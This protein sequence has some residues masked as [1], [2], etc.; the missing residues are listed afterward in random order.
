MNAPSG[1]ITA[2]NVLPVVAQPSSRFGVDPATL[3]DPS[4][5]IEHILKRYHEVHRG[6]LPELIR[7]A[8]KV[9]TV[10]AGHPDVPVGLVDL[11]EYMEQ[12]LLLHM[13]KEERM[14]FPLL[15]V[16]GNPFV[17]QPISMMRAEHIEHVV[18]LNKLATLTHDATPPEGA[19]S[20][21]RALYSGI[22]QLRNELIQHIDLENNVL[23]AQFDA[24]WEKLPGTPFEDDRK[25][26]Q[27]FNHR[28]TEQP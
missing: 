8:Q 10:H 6:Q 17:N 25:R 28:L 21:W 7:M 18:A 26:R 4:A 27:T 5:L 20:T 11:L 23:F 13:D 12:D 1:T 15:Q 14:L 19:C 9:A 16:G 24:L 2:V 22:A 3:N